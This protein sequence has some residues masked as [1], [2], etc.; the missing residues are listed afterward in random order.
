MS[1][2][3]DPATATIPAAKT[4]ADVIAAMKSLQSKLS[5]DDGLKWFNFLYLAVTKAVDGA[6]NATQ[7]ND[8]DW[9]AALDVVFANLYFNA[10]NTAQSGAGELPSAWKPLFEARDQPGITQIQFAL[11]GMNAHINRDLP[12]ALATLAGQDDGYPARGGERFQDFQ[13]VNGLLATVEARVK[14]QLLAGF[15]PTPAL[16]DI[17][18]MWSV[19]KAREAAWTNGEILWHLRSA[20][21]LRDGFLATL[22]DTVGLA[23]RGLLV[24]T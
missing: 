17:L 9:I 14:A 3:A 4:V 18:A 19:S 23:G 7:F 5:D 16:A 15:P 10:V 24:R 21:A 12:V 1:S 8:P 22:D 11:A 20:T 2:G 13:T 6:V